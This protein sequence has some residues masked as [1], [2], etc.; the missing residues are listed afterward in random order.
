MARL[1]FCRPLKR[2]KRLLLLETLVFSSRFSFRSGCFERSPTRALRCVTRHQFS[3]ARVFLSLLSK[4][5]QASHAL[6][7]RCQDLR[8]GLRYR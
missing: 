5:K 8:G 1:H 4:T 6:C 7:P 2:L 3:H